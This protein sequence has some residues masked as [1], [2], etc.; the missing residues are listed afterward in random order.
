MLYHLFDHAACYKH[1]YFA[2]R[3]QDTVTCPTTGKAVTPW[4]AAANTFL[5][6]YLEQVCTGQS[7]L[8]ALDSGCEYRKSF[9]PEYKSNRVRAD[10]SPLE[11][12]QLQKFKQWTL[13]VMA[14]MGA[15]LISVPG[16][17]ADDVLA[18]LASGEGVSGVLYT[19]DADLLQL[20]SDD[21]A[22]NLKGELYTAGMSYKGLPTHLTSVAKSLVGDASDHYPGIKGF[23]PA[24]L[25][26][27]IEEVGYDGLEEL[28]EIVQTGDRESL[29]VAVGLSPECKTLRKVLDNWDAWCGQWRL[30]QLHPELCWKPRASKLVNATFKKRVPDAEALTAAL[31]EGGI[32]DKLPEWLE[33]VPEAQLVLGADWDVMLPLIQQGMKEGDLVAYDY[34]STDY[35]QIEGFRQ[36]ATNPDFVDVLSQ[37]VSGVS[38]CFGEHRQHLIY[39]PVD[40]ADT[41]NVPAEKVKALLAWIKDQKLQLVAQNYSFEGTLNQTNFGLVLDNV[42]DTRIMMRYVDEN[43]SAHLKEMSKGLLGYQQDTY[44]ETLYNATASAFHAR[45]GLVLPQ[46][47]GIQSAGDPG[48]RDA[49]SEGHFPD[50][51][52]CRNALARADEVL[53]E[54]TVTRMCDLTG[55]QVLRYGC[56]DSL[57]TAHLW[58]LLQ[59]RLRL[60]HQWEHY[61][62]HAVEPTQVLQSA[63]IAGARVNWA[64][65]KRLTEQ[66]HETVSTR[67]AELRAILEEHVTGEETEGCRSY[68]DAE[69]K[70][71]DRRLHKENPSTA[72]ER[73]RAWEKK[74]RRSCAYVPYEE[75]EE[76]PKFAFTAKQVSAAAEAVGLPTLTKVTQTALGDY[77]GELELTTADPKVY[78]GDQKAFLDALMT[79]VAERVDKLPKE[80]TFAREAAFKA[81]A[82]VCQRL[83]NVQPKKIQ[84]GD[85]LNVGSSDQMRA[86]LY[87]K[88]GVPVRLYGTQLGIGRLKLGIKQAG[89]ATDEKAIQFALA[90]DAKEPWQKEALEHLLAIKKADTRIKL[91]HN[92]MPLWRHIDDRV[93]PSI[94]DSGTATRRPT[95]S[96]PNVL[97]MPGH[98]DGAFMR[99]M[100]MP[101]DRDWVC[102]AIDYS[103]Q[104]LRIIASESKDANMVKAYEPGNE[105]DIH[106]MTGVGIVQKLMCA[107]KF[108]S[109]IAS[110]E[111]F[112]KAR[113]D[114]H[115]PMFH[116]ADRIRKKAKA[117]N[118]L[119]SYLGTAPTLSRNLMVPLHEA[120]ELLEGTYALYASIVPWQDQVSKFMLKN[121]Y[122]QNAFGARRHATDQLYSKDKGAVK[123]MLR[124]GVNATVQGCAAEMLKVVLSNLYKEGW[125]ERLR[126]QFF[127][128]IYDEVV[129]WVHKGDVWAYWQVMQRLM[130]DATPPGHIVRQV[131]ELS[132]GGDWG[133]CVELGGH[134]SEEKVRETVQEALAQEAEVW[135]TDMT[136]TYEEVYAK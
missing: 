14:A 108:L 99:S 7:L 42:H 19:V 28:Q 123:R 127:A 81:L 40:H 54:V 117:C 60:E 83:A 57:V 84:I 22:V 78:E 98:G 76:M 44:Q 33:R 43:A 90:N 72:R 21:L 55:E 110:F 120:E 115:D 41:D 136:L 89:P 124:Q 86:L 5:D 63:Y 36:A 20:V 79:A 74:V 45:T 129:A 61:C 91:F 1:A 35:N 47:Q 8:V 15:T 87:C 95:G 26:K 96:S 52:A 73:L 106:S 2:T 107:D 49:V 75:F 92:T 69:R 93:H 132:I 101:P 51:T 71:M 29:E 34:E 64:L 17:E 48:V 11:K 97:Q 118:F 46:V 13:D 80:P 113:K 67:M 9:W 111:R 30:A 23:G 135:D 125:L 77:L 68:L 59:L 16:V 128:P 134:P 131:P 105:K 104:E 25:T 85:E 100:Y 3:V 27:L 12:E 32:E 122:T 70:Y 119:V 133:N 4:K 66:D 103:G 39:V 24:A 94:T 102:V 82:A 88:I 62:T 126:M 37:T 109:E 112:N 53:P 38:F 121:G 65:Q 31:R 6:L 56:D 10:Q 58:D 18:W 116:E 50:E 114:S 130:G